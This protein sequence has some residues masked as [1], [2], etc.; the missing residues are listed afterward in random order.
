MPYVPTDHRQYLSMSIRL[1]LAHVTSVQIVQ[2]MDNQEDM[3]QYVDFFCALKNNSHIYSYIKMIWWVT[4]N[5]PM[6]DYS[7]YNLAKYRKFICYYT[8]HH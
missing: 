1:G 4:M 2:I 6:N 5:V 8:I 7:R 3:I